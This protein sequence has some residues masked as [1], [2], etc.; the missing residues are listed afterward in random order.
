MKSTFRKISRAR[1]L[2]GNTTWYVSED[3]LL[4]AKLM[5][6]TV[7]YRRFYFRDLESVVVWPSRFWLLR[8]LVPGALLAT[9]GAWLWYSVNS[10][11]GQIFCG[12]A[13]AWVLLEMALGPTAR[14]RIRTTGASVDLPLVTRTRRASKVLAKIDAAVRASRVTVEVPTAPTI[15]PQA[16]EPTVAAAA[17]SNAS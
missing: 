2:F 13:A 9:L 8:P 11:A 15:V 12:L 17:E 7:D 6:Y 5:M 1:T 3:C 10:I 16:A 4:A 14:S